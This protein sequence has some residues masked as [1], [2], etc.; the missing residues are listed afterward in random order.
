VGGG[1]LIW[2]VAS[3]VMSAWTLWF[4]LRLVMRGSHA[5]DGA[6]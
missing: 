6:A 1:S 2:V 3:M 5:A 4:G